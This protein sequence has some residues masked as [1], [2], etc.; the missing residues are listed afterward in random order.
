MST[1]SKMFPKTEKQLRR[2]TPPLPSINK[3]KEELKIKSHKVAARIQNKFVAMPPL[4][5]AREYRE[6]KERTHHELVSICRTESMLFSS[7]QH[8][9]IFT[10]WFGYSQVQMCNNNEITTPPTK[11]KYECLGACLQCCGGECTNFP[12]CGNDHIADT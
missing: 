3:K 9:N 2:V 6:I 7:C 1:S 5:G 10:G 11:Q 12:S 4:W 8:C